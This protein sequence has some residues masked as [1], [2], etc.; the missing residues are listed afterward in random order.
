MANEHDQKDPQQK[1]E[2][3]IPPGGEAL[4]EDNRDVRKAA[5]EEQPDLENEGLG[6]YGSDA[7]DPSTGDERR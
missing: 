5:D 7:G 4:A 6:G 3:K 1:H 2:G